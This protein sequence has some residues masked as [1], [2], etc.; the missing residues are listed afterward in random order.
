MSQYYIT[1]SSDKVILRCIESQVHESKATMYYEQAYN[2]MATVGLSDNVRDP[3]WQYSLLS[4][5][6]THPL[7][8]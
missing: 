4:N 8:L 6:S 3:C 7:T 1:Y 2:R 5:Q